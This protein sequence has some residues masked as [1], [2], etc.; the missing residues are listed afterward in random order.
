M[1]TYLSWGQRGP[2]T[3]VPE[4]SVFPLWLSSVW[5]PSPSGGSVR[6]SVTLSTR[7]GSEP[8]PHPS[9]FP[10]WVP[11]FCFFLFLPGAAMVLLQGRGDPA[12][13]S[14]SNLAAALTPEKE[15]CGQLA[16]SPWSARNDHGLFRGVGGRG[17]GDT[18]PNDLMNEE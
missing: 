5:S 16:P 9:A 4:F 11:P 7:G 14:R 12:V 15:P 1:G 6:F 18:K 17:R 10:T 2:C 8:P 13:T 3:D